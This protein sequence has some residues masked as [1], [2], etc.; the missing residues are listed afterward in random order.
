MAPIPILF[1]DLATIFLLLFMSV[2]FIVGQ[3]DAQTYV[4]IH[5]RHFVFQCFGD[6]Q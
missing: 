4:Q 5:G 2:Y 3:M 6:D 1:L